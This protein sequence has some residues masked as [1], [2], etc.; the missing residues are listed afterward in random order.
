MSNVTRA[1]LQRNC[2]QWR[3]IR[4]ILHVLFA[5][6]EINVGPTTTTFD[7]ITAPEWPDYQTWKHSW[8][9]S[10]FWW[11]YTCERRA[12]VYF[13]D[14]LHN[15]L[16]L[17]VFVKPP[18][19]FLHLDLCVSTRVGVCSSGLSLYMA[20]GTGGN[21]GREKGEERAGR[22]VHLPIPNSWIRHCTVL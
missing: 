13:W 1:T 20:G 18:C 3:H 21:K 12:D 7:V 4:R 2:S 17:C 14:S 6:A 16:F 19:I 11:L 8:T 5:V 15:C 22:E 10:I 9:S